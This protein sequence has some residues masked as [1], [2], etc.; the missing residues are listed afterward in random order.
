M[1]RNTCPVCKE[2]A[3]SSVKKLM[4]FRLLKCQSCGVKLRL[5]F[6]ISIIAIIFSILVSLLISVVFE[7]NSYIGFG[8]GMVII[9]IP[10]SYFTPLQRE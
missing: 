10:V 3:M 5:N 1:S 4:G 2:L 6:T 7:L 9:F 8:I